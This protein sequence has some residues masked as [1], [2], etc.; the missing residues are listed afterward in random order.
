MEG[1]QTGGGTAFG[2]GVSRCGQEESHAPGE[3]AFL[4]GR[5]GYPGLIGERVLPAATAAAA[6]AGWVTGP[7]IENISSQFFLFFFFL[8]FFH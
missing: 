7:F 1:R 5:R 6:A 2:L 8:F 3:G 4:A